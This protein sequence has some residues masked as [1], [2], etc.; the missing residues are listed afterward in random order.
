MITVA[1]QCHHFEHRL[2][3]MLSS[4]IGQPVAVDIAHLSTGLTWQV[5]EKFAGLVDIRQ[6][7]YHDIDVLQYRG[8][9][10]TRQLQQCKTP[11]IL[12]A[13][14]DM[15]YHPEF[16]ARLLG[17]LDGLGDREMLTCGRWSQPNEQRR[18]TRRMIDQ[19]QPYPT[20]VSDP[21][22]KAD[23]LPKKRRGNVG[24]GFFQLVRVADCDGCYVDAENC[25]DHGWTDTY[26]KCRSDQQFRKRFTRKAAPRWY[27]ENQIHLNHLRD[28]ELGHHTE[29]Q[30]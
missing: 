7:V 5:C 11:Y 18:F 3:W 22:G 26:S 2:C 15:V 1:I 25:R 19:E 10:R 14:T 23:S 9:T 27:S 8:I 20:V 29:A 12:F 13:D 16:F 30:R 28:N 21:W 24:A 4:L 17:E 6:T